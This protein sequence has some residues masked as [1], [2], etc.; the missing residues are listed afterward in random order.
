MRRF[1]I[2]F[3]PFLISS[4]T[5]PQIA[6]SLTPDADCVE[7]F[8]DSKIVSGSKNCALSC[9]TLMT[10]MGTFIC[11]DQCD[12]LCR[13]TKP[14]SIP[15]K[16]I[17]YPGL[18]KAE[19]ELIVQNPKMSHTVFQL[20]GLAEDSTSRNFPDQN[21]NDESDAFR[22]FVWSGLLTKE[23]G[24]QKAKEYLDAHESNP[25]QSTRERK[26]D[27]FNNERGQSAAENLIRE[28]MWS[29]KA[30]ESKA[31]EELR[32]KILDVMIPG[33]NIPK[34]PK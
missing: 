9:A 5:S 3:L 25:L 14:D 30:L 16:F 29:L 32:N 34:E 26:M 19:K 8:R 1:I 4:I 12:E 31:I 2:G 7:W 28:N 18:T 13:P 17:F 33:L 20:K 21:L 11:P 27:T 22:H 6:Y 10:D 24:R 15:S 23:L